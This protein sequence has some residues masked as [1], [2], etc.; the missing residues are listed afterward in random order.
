MASARRTGARRL[1]VLAA[2]LAVLLTLAVAAGVLALNH[3][4]QAQTRASVAEATR[5][6]QLSE[7]ALDDQELE[8][9]SLLAVEG[10]REHQTD[11]AEGALLSAAQEYGSSSQV[12]PIDIESSDVSSNDVIASPGFNS[13]GV[14]LWDIS[15]REAIGTIDTTSAS[16]VPFR[17][18]GTRLAVLANNDDETQRLEF[19]DVATRMQ[20]STFDPR[21]E[22]NH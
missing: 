2:S 14:T 17:P 19:W 22:G 4:D 15:R 20:I 10:W 11:G 6:A 18:D 5:I 12:L 9:A 13:G 16:S 8:T 1:R 3:R 21:A 7:L